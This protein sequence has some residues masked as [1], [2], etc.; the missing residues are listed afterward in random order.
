MTALTLL[1]EAQAPPRV[2]SRGSLSSTGLT[3]E[4]AQ[5][6]LAKD[7]PNLLPGGQPRTLLAIVG[8]TV[9]EPMFLLLLTA[10]TLYLVFGDLQEG[11][12]LAGFVLVTLGLTLYQ[13]GKTERAIE[14]LRDLTSPRAL[15]M[16]DGRPQRIAGRDVVHGDLLHLGEGERVPADALRMNESL[17]TGDAMSVA[18]YAWAGQRLREG[19]ARAFAFTTLV[20]AN[21]A[22]IYSNRSGIRSLSQSLSTPNTAPWAVAGLALALLLGSLYLPAPVLHG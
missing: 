10:G 14:A 17:L 19:G 5:Q 22:L 2:A 4:E 7:G 20:I 21:L 11:L 3:A 18:A 13:E 15:V 9:R 12:T 16:R 1:Q 8:A 6:R